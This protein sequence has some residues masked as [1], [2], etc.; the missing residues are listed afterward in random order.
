[1]I[2]TGRPARIFCLPYGLASGQCFLR[3]IYFVHM[4][5]ESTPGLPGLIRKG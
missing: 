5:F 2:R 4:F 3:T 1:M